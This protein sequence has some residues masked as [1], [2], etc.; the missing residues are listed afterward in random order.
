MSSR[1]R[2]STVNFALLFGIVATPVFSVAAVDANHGFL[3]APA[4]SV[5]GDASAD[6]DTTGWD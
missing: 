4:A 5:T 6:P 1:V 2:K 3:S